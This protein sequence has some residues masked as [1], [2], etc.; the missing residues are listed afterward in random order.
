MTRDWVRVSKERHCPIC[1]HADWCL[2]S[3]DGRVAICARVSDGSVKR[4]GEAGY[5]H[6]LANSPERWCP[7]PRRLH[8]AP[9]PADVSALAA[10]CHAAADRGGHLDAL[11][12]QLGLS[13]ESL[14]RF[15][16]GWSERELC[17]TWP[18]SDATGRIIG[19]N[20]RFWDGAKRIVPG[21]KAGLYVPDDLSVAP[22]EPLLICEGGSDAAVG[23]DMGLQ[24]VGRFSCT[25]GATLLVELAKARR[26]GV[27]IIVADADEPGER[28]AE[29]LATALLPYVPALKVVRPPAPHKDLR[30]WRQAGAT[31]HD[32]HCLVAGVEPRRLVVKVRSA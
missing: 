32:V 13:V 8:V 29:S 28:G 12:E 31:L 21:H 24:C 19:I 20:R 5:L 25:H 26:P 16:V 10:E 4:C 2:V 1:D 11:A 9:Q 7:Q 27:L 15:R 6:R 14:R 17:S 30:A 18:M 22:G 3:A 23:R